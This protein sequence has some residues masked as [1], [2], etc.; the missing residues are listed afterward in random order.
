MR[1]SY[2]LRA[3]RGCSGPRL[4]ASAHWWAVSVQ[5]CGLAQLPHTHLTIPIAST[6]SRAPFHPSQVL[7]NP[8]SAA[9]PTMP[10]TIE[11]AD[12]ETYPSQTTF[13]PV[14]L[15]FYLQLVLTCVI[16]SLG[17]R[18]N[19][20]STSSASLA[21]STPSRLGLSADVSELTLPR[22]CLEA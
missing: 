4:S 2:C 5:A 3:R 19:S 7:L 13:Q 11:A 6:Q 15:R 16:S 12:N 8:D 20:K 9:Q 18:P 17:C 1:L 14:L 22:L 10:N 21:L